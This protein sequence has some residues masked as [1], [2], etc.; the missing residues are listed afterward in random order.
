MN[1]FFIKFALKL[2]ISSIFLLFG[3]TNFLTAK[4]FS[5]NLES[6][7]YIKITKILFNNKDHFKANKKFKIMEDIY[8]LQ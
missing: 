1:F 6:F 4:F 5:K 2:K 8:P 7:F 3:I